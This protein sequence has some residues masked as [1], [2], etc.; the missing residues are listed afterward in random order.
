M[1]NDLSLISK[2]TKLSSCAN[3]QMDDVLKNLE[4]MTYKKI[5]EQHKYKIYYSESEKS[6][7]TYL[8][9]DSKKINDV[10]LKTKVKR[11]L[12]NKLLIFISLMQKKKILEHVL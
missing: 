11:T 5:L 1:M 9:D 10:Q 4:I 8:P 7:R 6:W 2:L 3:M 12:K